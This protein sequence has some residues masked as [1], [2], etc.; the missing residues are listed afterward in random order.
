MK[1]IDI[2]VKNELLLDK[3]V[4]LKKLIGKEVLSKGGKMIGKITEIRTNPKNLNLEG[5]VVRGNIHKNLMYIGKSYFSRLSDEAIILNI[6]VSV[7]VKDRQVITWDGKV[8][9]KVKEVVRKGMRNDLSGVYVKSFF[10]RKFFIPVSAIDYFNA[11]VVLKPKYNA[12][13]KYFWQKDK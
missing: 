1:E 12:R 7:L 5:I 8:L 11:S 4:N 10:S 6:E 2:I 9:G 13:K 3:T